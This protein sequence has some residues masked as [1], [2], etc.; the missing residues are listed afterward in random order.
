MANI[1]ATIAN[2]TNKEGSEVVRP[3]HRLLKMEFKKPEPKEIEEELV[4]ETVKQKSAR[5]MS[6]TLAQFGWRLDEN[7][8]VVRI[9]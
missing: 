7:G 9:S 2:L 6:N 3:E 8:A 1:V 4:E 5:L